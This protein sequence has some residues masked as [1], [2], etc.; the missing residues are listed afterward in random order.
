MRSRLAPFVV[1]ILAAT[2]L[3]AQNSIY[4][5]A[6]L[7]FPGRSLGARARALGGGVALFDRES[8]VNPASTGAFRFLGAGFSVLSSSRNYEA[9]G[10]RVDNLTDTRFP[11][12]VVGS[13]IGRGPFSF[14]VGYSLFMERT[15]DITTT[16]Q[17]VLRGDSVTAEDRVG[18]DGG[19]SDLRFSLARKFGE[20][21]WLGV[22]GHFVSGSTRS[23][24]ARVFSN[25]FFEPVS[26]TEDVEYFANGVSV[27]FILVPS[28]VF[29]V[30]G[31]LRYS[32]DIGIE[33][34]SGEA[35]KVAMPVQVAVGVVFRPQ[36]AIRWSASFVH[37]TWGRASDD[38]TAIGIGQSFN[39]WEVG[40]GI[41]IGGAGP[42]TSPIPLRFGLRYAQLPFS[43][44]GEQP[45]EINLSFGTGIRFASE[46]A[47]LDVTIE[48]AIREGAGARE[49][50]WLLTLGIGVR[51]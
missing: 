29:Q 36:L 25:P 8:G 9:L 13:N 3:S 18:S 46:R 11:S 21:F 17:I 41:E 38:L 42:G 44:S 5:L 49:K 7:G 40:T 4:G 12:A 22:G 31:S 1:L 30:G 24:V 19:I 51:P 26:Q 33:T 16:S 23:S 15:Y 37:N 45:T 32:G 28:D 39:T 27:G 14:S 10:N 35:S 43:V 47:S 50:A 6:G 2:S 20:S 34:A 48:R